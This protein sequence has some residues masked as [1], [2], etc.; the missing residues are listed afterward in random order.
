MG[1][2]IGYDISEATCGHAGAAHD[3]LR[4]AERP[5]FSPTC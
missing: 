2:K 4:I 1:L 3:P 5:A